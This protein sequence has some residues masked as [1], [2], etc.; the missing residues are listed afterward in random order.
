MD[1]ISE[2]RCHLQRKVLI[3]ILKTVKDKVAKNH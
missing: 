3:D 2:I 1:R